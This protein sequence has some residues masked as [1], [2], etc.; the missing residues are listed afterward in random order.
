MAGQPT[1]DIRSIEYSI[2]LAH[3]T[4]PTKSRN[5]EKSPVAR[6][7]FPPYSCLS[8]CRLAQPHRLWVWLAYLPEAVRCALR[9]Q[10]CGRH[11]RGRLWVR[12]LLYDCA[13]RGLELFAMLRSHLVAHRQACSKP[14]THPRLFIL[15]SLVSLSLHA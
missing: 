3:F 9:G 7:A 5:D 2:M 13:F 1:H 4:R 6:A 14:P 8:T 12:P 15:R 10:H 11:G